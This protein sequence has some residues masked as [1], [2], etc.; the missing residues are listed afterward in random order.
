MAR[1]ARS[2]RPTGPIPP[3]YIYAPTTFDGTIRDPHTDDTF[4]ADGPGHHAYT[5]RLQTRVSNGR[6]EFLV[7]A[8]VGANHPSDVLTPFPIPG[9]AATIAPTVIVSDALGRT[10]T[11]TP[12]TPGLTDAVVAHYDGSTDPHEGY[13]RMWVPFT[14]LNGSASLTEPGFQVRVEIR[15]TS[16]LP[17]AGTAG[18]TGADEVQVHLGAEPVARNQVVDD[19]AGVAIDD[20]A[21]V[22][23]PGD[24]GADD[25]QHIIDPILRRQLK[26]IIESKAPADFPA[27]YDW[28]L[29]NLGVTKG[30]AHLSSISFTGG[31]LDSLGLQPVNG[32]ESALVGKVSGTATLVLTISPRAIG[33][34]ESIVGGS[35][36]V[37]ADVDATATVSAGLGLEPGNTRP[38]LQLH[39]D[40]VQASV[41]R[42]YETGTLT[43]F[44]ILAPTYISCSD[45]HDNFTGGLQKQV[46]DMLS[47]ALKDGS[48]N[49]A[50]SSAIDPNLLEAADLSSGP[51]GKLRVAQDGGFGV[52][53][54][55]YEPSV[56][57]DQGPRPLLW[58]RG[59]DA[60]ASGAIT[61]LGGDRFPYSSRP[62]ATESTFAATHERTRPDG[63]GFDLGAVVSGASV[64]QLAR[65]LSAGSGDGAGLLDINPTPDSAVTVRP[66]SALQYLPSV[67]AGW[68][69]TGAV[70]AYIPSLRIST[71]VPETATV[72][73]DVY[74]GVSA[75]IDVTTNQVVFDRDVA[76]RTR[77][78]RLDPSI[79]L[80]LDRDPTGAGPTKIQAI[81]DLIK[82]QVGQRVQ[83]M[84]QSIAVPNVSTF[85]VNADLP[86]LEASH[87][88][89]ANV[90]GNLGVYVDVDPA[91]THVSVS[92]DFDTP[93]GAAP[94][95]VTLNASTAGFP[96]F[97]D[98]VV[99]W[100]VVDGATRATVYDSPAQGEAPGQLSLTL[101]TSGLYVFVNE[102]CTGQRWVRVIATATVTQ[103]GVTDK[104]DGDAMR[105]YTGPPQWD[106]MRC[107]HGDDN[108]GGPDTNP[109]GGDQRPPILE[110]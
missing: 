109:G 67:P 100:H 72:A 52:S 10:S 39:V 94:N 41:S 90:G 40:D 106:P 25:L 16:A 1:T 31:G 27:D 7:C 61:D 95:S 110:P 49:D 97:G 60:V 11:Y 6:E 69:T 26:P 59:I 14:P 4:A 86:A 71:P 75:H 19:A 33:G 79:E 70:Q 104:G 78:L 91:P 105:S 28:T 18:V 77:F 37:Q 73:A 21:L 92:G 42:L 9:H 54:W 98:P 29:A 108:P 12:S 56:T 66:S 46:S 35:C 57:D 83:D 2:P 64:N 82:D 15:G 53:G 65:A 22:D 34:L 102:P 48:L 107:G 88:S 76:V 63:S 23:T 74:V 24:P 30:P 85:L 103:A 96:H 93:D 89:L 47:D 87:L 20:G 3:G 43:G 51:F 58:N 55:H 8:H 62:S 32:S 101:P 80:A 68:P 38:K 13:L 36:N 17:L 99:H 50:V 45:L 5:G 84:F 81:G 44:Y